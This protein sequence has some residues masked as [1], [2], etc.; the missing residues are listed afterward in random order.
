MAESEQS[1]DGQ[2][3]RENIRDSY[4]EGFDRVLRKVLD[5]RRTLIA[6]TLAWRLRPYF[7]HLPS[8]GMSK[9]P[10]SENP[11][12]PVE[13]LSRLRSIVG[14]RFQNLRTRWTEAGLPLREHRG[15]RA[16]DY[17]V[18]E[19]GWL[20]LSSWILKQGYESRLTPNQVGCVMELRKK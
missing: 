14:G 16:E 17:A 3:I 10:D 7:R 11:W 5:H 20:A 8:P 4:F 18:D 2:K 15:D 9:S 1:E 12:E 19:E 13:S 6:Q